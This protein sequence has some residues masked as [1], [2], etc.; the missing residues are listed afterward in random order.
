M[1]IGVNLI[2]YT[3]L[4]G[5]E[6]FAQ[7]L[8]KHLVLDSNTEIILFTNQ[9]SAQ[10]FTNNNPRISLI[11]KNF[12]KL[13]KLN[14][15]V[16]QQGGFIRKLKK[17]KIDL[18]FCPSIASPLLYK[19]KI[20]TIHDLAPYRFSAEAG[21]LA[22]FY[23]WLS[24]LS[25]K[26]FSQGITTVSEFSKQ[27]IIDLLKIR[28][29][30]IT[31]LSEGV[32]EMPTINEN[33][34]KEV[35]IKFGLSAQQKYFIYIGNIRPRKNLPA[36]LQAFQLFLTEQPNFIFIIAG[37]R[38]KRSRQLE[39]LTKKLNLEKQVLFTG[40][41]SPQEKVALLQKS[42]GLIFASLYEGFGLPILEAQSLGVP[43][44]SSQSSALPEISNRG[45]ILINPQSPE[46]I[47]KG[48]ILL[49]R[50]ENLRKKII[51]AGQENAKKYSWD[52]AAADLLNLCKN[53]ENIRNK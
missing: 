3:E 45:A 53:Y 4:Q 29:N 24:F 21:I 8:L 31:I 7:N 9:K 18:L 51:I 16:Y 44:L 12:S 35:L 23:F 2:Q 11:T 1:R 22:R 6:I 15:I 34:Q 25:A 13:N 47:K 50:D 43:V 14:L 10:F 49:A 32:P 38:D 46:E 17:E 5:I 36:T 28:A 41:L 52:R 33:E 48:M 19:N 20:V 30:R 42:T 40:W 39:R 26:Y 27:E 37:K